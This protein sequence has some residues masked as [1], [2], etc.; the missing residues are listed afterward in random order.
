MLKKIKEQMNWTEI[1]Q[2]KITC[3]F[4]LLFY[5]IG[6]RNVFLAE[7]LYMMR[8]FVSCIFLCPYNTVSPILSL[9]TNK[10]IY[11]FFFFNHVNLE[12]VFLHVWPVGTSDSVW[13]KESYYSWLHYN[14]PLLIFPSVVNG[15]AF[16]LPSLKPQRHFWLFRL[17]F[18]PRA[19]IP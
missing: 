17:Y 14:S 12:S 3:I 5:L 4:N 8:N 18:T 7:D 9:E 16:S 13:P 10:S 6:A 1:Y 11:F 19:G 15:I 2:E